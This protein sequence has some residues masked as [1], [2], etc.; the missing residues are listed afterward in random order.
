[1]S[2]KQPDYD[3]ME[4][5]NVIGLTCSFG[6]RRRNP[7]EVFGGGSGPAFEAAVFPDGMFMLEMLDT[8]SQGYLFMKR[9]VPQSALLT[10][11]KI[12]NVPEG[13]QLDDQ[14][15]SQLTDL[16]GIEAFRGLDCMV[17]STLQPFPNSQLTQVFRWIVHKRYVPKTAF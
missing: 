13:S 7:R 16:L 2:E 5:R 12:L 8:C 6:A 3:P 15:H 10:V 4:D 1:M 17:E 14:G 9:I 11:E